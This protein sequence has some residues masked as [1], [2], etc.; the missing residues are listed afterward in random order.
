M[1]DQFDKLFV[2]RLFLS[3]FELLVHSFGLMNFKVIIITKM[4]RYGMKI[5][6]RTDYDT[7]Y[8]LR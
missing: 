2:P 1:Y 7:A 4:A 3:L 5:Y 6:V 8:V